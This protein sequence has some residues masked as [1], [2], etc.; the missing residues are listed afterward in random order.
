MRYVLNDG[1]SDSDDS[2]AERGSKGV[3]GIGG[4]LVSG[5]DYHISFLQ[6]TVN[7]FD[8]SKWTMQIS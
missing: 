6:K 8:Q 3:D 7:M 2:Q 4:S 1:C 5:S